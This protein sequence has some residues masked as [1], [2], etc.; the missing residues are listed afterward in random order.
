VKISGHKKDAATFCTCHATNGLPGICSISWSRNAQSNGLNPIVP[1][2]ATRIP[3][4]SKVAGACASRVAAGPA[5]FDVWQRNNNV[6]QSASRRGRERLTLSA[7]WAQITPGLMICL[8][9]FTALTRFA[10]I[11]TNARLIQACHL[12]SSR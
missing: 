10:G 8:H 2:I 5:D 11:D 7:N 6:R 9:I 1:D 12:W 4:L 3:R